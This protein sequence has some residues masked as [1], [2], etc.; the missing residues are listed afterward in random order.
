MSAPEV[1]IKNLWA[2]GVLV[3][4]K[5]QVGGRRMRGGNRQEHHRFLFSFPAILAIVW[6]ESSR[7]A[8]AMSLLLT[9]GITMVR[10][11]ISPLNPARATDIESMLRILKRFA[12]CMPARFLNSVRVGPG[13]RMVTV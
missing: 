11:R 12:S 8:K 4:K 10:P 7:E 5:T 1:K 9:P 13:Q 6:R 3:Q 2:S